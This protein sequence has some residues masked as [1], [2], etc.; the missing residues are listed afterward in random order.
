MENVALNKKGGMI[1]K[2]AVKKRKGFSGRGAGA[3]LKGF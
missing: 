1:K 2:S 3:A